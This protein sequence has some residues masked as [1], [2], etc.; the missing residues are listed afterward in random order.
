MSR[1][2][3]TEALA[4]HVESVTKYAN[5]YSL[6]FTGIMTTI[7]WA[8]GGW[9]TALKVLIAFIAIDIATGVIIGLFFEKSFSSRRLRKG[10]GTKIGYLI[11]I[12]LCN[13]LDMV[14]FVESPILRTASI[15]FYVAVEGSSIVENLGKMGVPIPK[16]LKEK[17]AQLNEEHVGS[18]EEKK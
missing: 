17:L 16:Q 7:T 2:L 11:V 4:R 6:Y 13:L 9:D 10:F 8:L 15:Y 1:I 5:E 18:E 3:K 14:F 12:M